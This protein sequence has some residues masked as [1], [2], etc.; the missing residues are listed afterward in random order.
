MTSDTT[1]VSI[2]V[3]TVSVAV[4]CAVTYVVEGE[5]TRTN[6]C[7]IHAPGKKAAIE[8]PVVV[9]GLI[10]RKRVQKSAPMDSSR[11]LKC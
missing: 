1:V 11:V 4:V 10:C 9:D 5:N 2:E 3:V 6:P 7:Q 8:I